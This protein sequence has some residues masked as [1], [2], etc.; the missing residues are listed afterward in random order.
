[1]LLRPQSLNDSD[2]IG[3]AAVNIHQEPPTESL[4]RLKLCLGIAER[5]DGGG[6]HLEDWCRQTRRMT[7]YHT[8]IVGDTDKM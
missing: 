5:S 3:D 7:G 6:V 4:A 1:M 8:E 2:P